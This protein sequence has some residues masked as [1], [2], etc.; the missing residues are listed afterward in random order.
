M[1]REYVRRKIAEL[2]D[3]EPDEIPDTG[4]LILEHGMDSLIFM[5]LLYE[6]ENEFEITVDR[7]AFRIEMDFSELMELIEGKSN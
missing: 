6:L 1:D 3:I 4:S 2:M 5:E 7:T